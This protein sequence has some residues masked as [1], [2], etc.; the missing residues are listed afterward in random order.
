MLKISFAFYLICFQDFY[1]IMYKIRNFSFDSNYVD[2]LRAQINNWTDS[3]NKLNKGICTPYIHSLQKHVPEMIE[4][5]HNINLFNIQ[6][7]E[8]LNDLST[9][10]YYSSTNKKNSGKTYLMQLM[11]K[12]NRIEYFNLTK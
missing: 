5:Y 3:F 8:K 7:L 1:E 9:T 6:G 2:S 10:Y 4:K 11:E 12:R